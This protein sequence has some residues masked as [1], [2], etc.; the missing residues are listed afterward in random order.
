MKVR[1]GFVSNSSSSSFVLA[2]KKDAFD[3]WRKNEDPIVQA[4]AEATMHRDDIFGIDC[5]VY[6]YA[7]SEGGWFDNLCISDIVNRGNEI[8]KEQNRGVATKVAIINKTKEEDIDDSWLHEH[9]SECIYEVGD[10]FDEISKDKVWSHG[11]DW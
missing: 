8:A 6:E 11:M 5:M 3:E 1:I 9:V 4:M 10:Y 2:I 7:S